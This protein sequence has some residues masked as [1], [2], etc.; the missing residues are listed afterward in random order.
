[1]RTTDIQAEDIVTDE[2]VGKFIPD[3]ND[4]TNFHSMGRT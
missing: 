1:M 2:P 3:P 4:P